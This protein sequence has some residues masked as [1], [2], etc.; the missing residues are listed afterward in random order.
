MGN[1]KKIIEFR[2]DN[3]SQFISQE[4]AY[5]ILKDVS[6][7]FPHSDKISYFPFAP[8]H[9]KSIS[10]RHFA[11]NSLWTGQFENNNKLCNVNDVINAIINGQKN[12]NKKRK[13]DGK[14]IIETYAFE[15]KLK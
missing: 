15:D 14:R 3:A 10:D 2:F 1:T 5:F 8:R 6:K 4:F 13:A 7:F 9:G 12:A 11:K